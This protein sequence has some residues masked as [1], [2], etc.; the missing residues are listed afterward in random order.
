M[1]SLI[2]GLLCLTTYASKAQQVPQLQLKKA[3]EPLSLKGSIIDSYQGLN[4]LT[5]DVSQ[6]PKATSVT[7]LPLDNM[8]CLLVNLNYY[9]NKMPVAALSNND[10]VGIPTKK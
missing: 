3:K 1:K 8:H 2:I 7:T 10:A 4:N 5:L 6:P 9:I